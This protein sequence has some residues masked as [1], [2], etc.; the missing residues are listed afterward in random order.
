MGDGIADDGL[1]LLG[2][3]GAGV[4]IMLTPGK[5][6]R[7][8]SN[9]TIGTVWAAGG[10]ISVDAGIT[11]TVK[12]VV[13]PAAA[14]IFSGLGIVETKTRTYSVA[15]FAGAS[16]NEKWDMCRRSFLADQHYTCHWPR[17]DK[18][19]AAAVLATGA[20]G[21]RGYMWRVTAPVVFDDPEN[22][23]TIIS[24]AKL[25]VTAA[26]DAALLFST[27]NKTE[28]INFPVGLW[29]EGRYNCNY[30]IRINGGARL[31]F[32]G[33][34]HTK[35]IKMDGVYVEPSL[36]ANAVAADQIQFE[37]LN[38]TDYGR[39]GVNIVGRPQVQPTG[40][41]NSIR[42]GFLFSNGGAPA[43]SYGSS[44]PVALLRAAGLIR[45]LRVDYVQENTAYSG[46][47]LDNSAA[48]VL[49]EA[50]DEG[51]PKD[52]VVEQIGMRGNLAKAVKAINSGSGSAQK[53]TF[54]VGRITNNA[55]AGAIVD[56]DWTDSVELGAI[57][58]GT[59][60]SGAVTHSNT[61]DLRTS[62]ITT[63]AISGVADRM[64]INGALTLI[65]DIGN[66][67]VNNFSVSGYGS[68]LVILESADP[69]ANAIAHLSGTGTLTAVS[70]GS[71]ATVSS[72]TT[73][74][75]STGTSGMVNLSAN[76]GR[77][78]VENRTG[79]TLKCKVKALG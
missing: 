4:P 38:V 14:V 18:T 41:A 53:S 75:G 31:K 35:R 39:Y 47:E 10:V 36:P 16:L 19:D 25:C 66:N 34:V 6:Y 55:S 40:I 17:P 21:T 52:V 78:Y 42:I 65:R 58:A 77:V 74:V 59:L 57:N 24:D 22:N 51:A 76:N 68:M 73:L 45:G 43:A 56:L 67:S 12:G 23:G 54:R 44:A 71:K 48:L 9:R 15:W 13:G 69:A 8:S 33:A 79:V 28:E 49:I 30:G 70:V 3:G 20:E 27:A 63:E 61:S 26:C 46:G 2:A 60:Y 11:L 64:L 32:G 1:Y 7:V 29:V 62:G 5:T 72:N 50:N 37:F